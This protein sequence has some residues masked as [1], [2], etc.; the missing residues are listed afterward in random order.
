MKV[1]FGFVCDDVRREDNGKLIFIG[2]YSSDIVVP[3]L[4]AVL[5][6]T[7]VV[8]VEMKGEETLELQVRMGDTLLRKGKGKV[9]SN[10][11]GGH[12]VPIPSIV[13]DKLTTEGR[14]DF[15]VR[16]GDGDWVTACSLPLRLR[17]RPSA[18]TE[19]QQPS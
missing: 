1:Q 9:R 5:I 6:L 13:L 16:L 2:A 4:P 11:A 10:V 19:P 3:A 8:R 18:A 15:E 17:E 7:L 14:L 12:W